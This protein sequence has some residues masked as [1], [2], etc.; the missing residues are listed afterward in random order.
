MESKIFTRIDLLIQFIGKSLSWLNVVMVLVAFSVVVLRYFFQLGWVWLQDIVVYS[1]ALLFMGAAAY[2]LQEDSHVRVDIFYQKLSD[3][4]K[5]LSNFLGCLF[6]LIPF[7]I[8]ILFE[9]ST[10]VFNSWKSFEGAKDSGGLHGV[11][12]VKSFIFLYAG[13]LLLQ[14]LSFLSRNWRDFRNG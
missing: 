13:L 9:S 3:S 7:C 4:K 11:F 14:S 12:F 1:N 5:S 6:L 10:F 2:V 8:F